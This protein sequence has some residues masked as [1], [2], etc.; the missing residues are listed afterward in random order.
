[1]WGAS[2]FFKVWI[3]RPYKGD[4][5]GFFAMDYSVAR[6]K[7]I[8]N[9]ILPNKVTD[10]RVIAA[11]AEIPRESFVPDELKGVAY[12]DEAVALGNGRFVVAPLVLARLLQAASVGP[13]DVALV[14]GGNSGYSTALMARLASTVVSLES[15]KGLRKKASKALEKLGIDTVAG[16]KGPLEEGY[17]AQGPYDVIFFDGALGAV[18]QAIIDQLA[19]GGRLVAVVVKEAAQASDVAGSGMGQGILMVRAGDNISTTSIFDAGTPMIDGF[20]QKEAF[21]F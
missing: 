5:S 7:M 10:P 20:A 11:L 13:E 4:T 15:D 3:Y 14:V 8:E 17:G 18:P 19:D 9:Q 1:V 2:G 21:A 6:K 16:V 12:M